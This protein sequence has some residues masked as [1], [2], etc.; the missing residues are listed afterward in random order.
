MSWLAIGIIIGLFLLARAFAKRMADEAQ[1][2]RRLEEKVRIL[3]RTTPEVLCGQHHCTAVYQD[4]DIFGWTKFR[5]NTPG[6]E[7]EIRVRV[8]VV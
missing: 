7:H 3:Q 2:R 6:A 4:C 8:P 1:D 5:C